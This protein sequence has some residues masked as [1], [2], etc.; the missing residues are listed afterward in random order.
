M[1]HVLYFPIT[2]WMNEYVLDFLKADLVNM[3]S[4]IKFVSTSLVT[5]FCL[6]EVCEGWQFTHIQKIY[7]THVHDC[8]ISPRHEV[9]AYITSLAPSLSTEG[10]CI[11]RGRWAVMCK[12]MLLS[13]VRGPG[14]LILT[15]YLWL[16]TIFFVDIFMG[17]YFMLFHFIMIIEILWQ[18]Y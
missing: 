9:W 14:V 13:T 7:E 5:T 10:A 8:S 16:S 12:C 4:I 17:W 3:V 6:F 1:V 11:K 15:L 2:N 18:V